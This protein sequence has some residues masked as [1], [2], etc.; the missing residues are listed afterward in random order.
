MPSTA[1]TRALRLGKLRT[2]FERS[3]VNDSSVTTNTAVARSD[4]KRSAL[5]EMSSV[6]HSST[7]MTTAR[8][9][10]NASTP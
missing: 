4:A 9:K 10:L 6:G 2:G 3:T 7:N 1:I 5:K 8:L